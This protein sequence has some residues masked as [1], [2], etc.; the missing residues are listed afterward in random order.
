M[1][2][3]RDELE[4]D[5]GAAEP[6]AFFGR[7]LEVTPPTRLSWTSEEC[8]EGAVV[9]TMGWVAVGAMMVSL[10]MLGLAS[11]GTKGVRS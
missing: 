5:N 10:V 11:R 2:R 9:T 7:Y 1:A 3:G 6:I 4:P 8:D